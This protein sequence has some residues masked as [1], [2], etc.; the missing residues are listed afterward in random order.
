MA[1]SMETVFQIWDDKHGDRIEVGQDMDALDM[2]EIRQY[3]DD[4]RIGQRISM[5]REQALFV[6]DAM[7]KYLEQTKPFSPCPIG[8]VHR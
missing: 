8:P 3:S 4:G 7:Q 5:P 2:L 6:V 1:Y